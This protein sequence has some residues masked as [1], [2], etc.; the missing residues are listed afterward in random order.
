MQDRRSFQ[1]IVI[2]ALGA[3]ISGAMAIPAVAYLFATPK[4]KRKSGWIE[5]GDI[6]QVPLNSPEEVVFRRTRID[7]WKTSAERTSVWVIKRSPSEVIAL[8]P[9]CTHL[10][11]A[12]H[13]SDSSKTFECPCH[14]SAFSMDGKVLSGPAPRPLDRYDVKLEGTKLLLG[15]VKRSV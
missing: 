6:A 10:G 8:A 3:V 5:A 9:Q 11:C 13:W 2:A 7:G 12:Y 4:S 14:T 1:Q 15:E